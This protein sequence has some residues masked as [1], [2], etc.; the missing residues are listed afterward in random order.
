[1]MTLIYEY[2][3]PDPNRPIRE[4]ERRPLSPSGA[5]IPFTPDRLINEGVIGRRIDELST[6]VGTYGMGGPGFFG[7]RLGAEWLVIALWGAADWILVEGR[8][9]TD[10]FYDTNR[11]PKPWITNDEDDLSEQI[12]GQAIASI[13]IKRHSLMISLTN[14][15]D[16]IIEEAAD[17]RPL[18]EGSK[19]PRAFRAPD[20]LH[21]AVFL[22]PTNEIWV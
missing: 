13:E 10:S 9:I 8:L 11:R 3:I 5:L 17:N 16:M 6:H 7:L 19:E 14:G 18:F 22:S 20:D 4:S 15:L 12:V 21:R 1:M 2:M